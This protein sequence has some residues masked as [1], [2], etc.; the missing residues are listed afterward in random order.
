LANSG[1][2]DEAD[3]PAPRLKIRIETLSDLVFGLALSIGSL[4]LID[5]TP[6]SGQ[7]LVVYVGEFGFGF[8][9]V[10]MTW[11]GYSRTMAAL[12][13]EAPFALPANLALLFVV[14]LEPYLFF[15]LDSSPT[16]D[17]A[18]WASVA[19]GLDL[20][21][22]F[23]LQAGLAYVVVNEAKKGAAAR[24]RLHP[25]VVARFRRWMKLEVVAGLIFA[26]STL[27]V[28][29]VAVPGG[30]LRFDVWFLSLAL[31]LGARATAKPAPASA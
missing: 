25:A 19:Y 17:M 8:L 20:G 18:N 14:I 7:D 4:F 2:P 23:F 9:I 26:V 28:F 12:P 3:S 29:W 15:V 10:V 6:Q 22:L 13:E 16:A 11:L 24:R 30:Q 1:S 27:P 5:K 31:F 21:G